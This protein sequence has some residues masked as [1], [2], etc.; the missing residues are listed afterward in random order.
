MLVKC[1]DL[2]ALTGSVCLLMLLELSCNLSVI[3]PGQLH[4]YA[5][6]SHGD[7]SSTRLF[8]K[9]T[10]TYSNVAPKQQ[11]THYGRHAN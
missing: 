7:W 8:K 3:I 2:V 5:R 4:H 11:V 1:I 9:I 6:L 10:E